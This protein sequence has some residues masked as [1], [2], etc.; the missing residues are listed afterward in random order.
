MSYTE[1][2]MRQIRGMAM[3]RRGIVPKLVLSTR[4]VEKMAIAARQFIADETGEAMIGLVV[5]PEFED[6]V[7]T[8]YVMD[9]I[10]PDDD[11][12]VRRTHTFQQ[13]DDLQDEII[14]WLQENWRIRR[15]K[16]QPDERIPLDGKWD[17]PLRYVGD[18]HKQPGSMITPSGGDLMTALSWL[19]DDENGMEYLLVPIV[20]L[21]HPNTTGDSS[22]HVNYITVDQGDGTNMR[23][24]WWYIHRD[25]GRFQA[26][27]PVVVASEELPDLTPYPWHLSKDDRF[28]HEVNLLNDDGLF[29]TPI[30]WQAHGKPP[31]EMCLM[32]ARQGSNKLMVVVT[33]TSFPNSA[34]KAYFVP[35]SGLQAGEDMY[36]LFGR[37][38]P[39]AEKIDEPPGFKWTS[40]KYLIQYVH[41]I[42]D[43]LGIKRVPP[44]QAV[45]VQAKEDELT[46][47]ELDRV[48]TV[49][50]I[51]EVATTD[52]YSAY[53]D[54]DDDEHQEDGD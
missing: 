29:V 32:M 6:G 3:I 12:A 19:D 50:E 38:W 33:D 47:D 15:E 16:P 42:E 45:A 9:T 35:Y 46:E 39:R 49:N 41:A 11:T 18:W 10:S 44:R 52:D 4:V 31:M 7:P 54:E 24:D 26:I 2:M 14:W 25:V 17:V 30:L 36:D 34:P 28:N 5:P 53:S 1:L 13:G 20:T 23:V 51:A 8:I 40:D 37:L 43:H 22:A 27:N 48:T 21:G